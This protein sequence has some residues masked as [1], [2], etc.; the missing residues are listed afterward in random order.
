MMRLQ[1]LNWVHLR[2]RG[3][4]WWSDSPRIWSAKTVALSLRR[5]G[6]MRSIARTAASDSWR[7]LPGNRGRSGTWSLVSGRG[8]T[9][10][11]NSMS[12]ANSVGRWWSPAAVVMSTARRVVRRVIGLPPA[13]MSRQSRSGWPR[14]GQRF[15]WY[16]V[17][18][19]PQ[20]RSGDLTAYGSVPSAESNTTWTRVGGM[21]PP[22][23]T[24]ALT[25]ASQLT[26][27]LR[28]V[29]NATENTVVQL[30]P[31]AGRTT[32]SGR[33]AER[34]ISR[35]TLW[36]ATQ[37]RAVGQSTGWSTL[38]SGNRLTAP[39]PKDG[40]CTISTGIR[41]I[42]A[43]KTSWRCLLATTTPTRDSLPTRSAS[44]IWKLACVSTGFLSTNPRDSYRRTAASGLRPGA[45]VLCP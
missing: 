30:G 34:P 21:R 20:S 13:P 3:A 31:L 38:W 39:S 17:G 40:M 42:L 36:S 7:R 9:H 37:T 44:A 45:A 35:G 32:G 19:V 14:L 1:V 29:G 5:N 18:V 41:Q 12:P 22:T 2:E 8:I 6:V 33:A 4:S 24:S 28:G 25:V 23:R 15:L 27:K 11:G 10:G 43:S 26:A 16:A